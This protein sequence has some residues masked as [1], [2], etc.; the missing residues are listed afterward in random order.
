[1]TLRSEI[2]A[3]LAEH[4]AAHTMSLEATLDAVLRCEAIERVREA[5]RE[6]ADRKGPFS[7]DPDEHARNCVEHMG[8][9]AETALSLLETPD[10]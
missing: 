9:Y 7:L 8:S 2:E 4:V 1:M 6:I 10:A 5:L 3:V